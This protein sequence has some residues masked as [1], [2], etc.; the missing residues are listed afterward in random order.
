M[1]GHKRWVLFPPETPRELVKPP[2]S[3]V[4]G[5][6]VGWFAHH[7][8]KVCLA[9]QGRIAR[10]GLV[11]WLP[12]R[13]RA[14]ARD[15]GQHCVICARQ[16]RARGMVMYDVVQRPGQTIFVPSG[17]WHVVVNLDATV[18][19]QTNQTSMCAGAVFGTWVCVV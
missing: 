19:H 5:E 17:W 4:G 15:L 3:A 2:R 12:I 7:L 13:G 14:L 11:F 6:A 9:G 10:L 18:R 16:L 8:P 1:A